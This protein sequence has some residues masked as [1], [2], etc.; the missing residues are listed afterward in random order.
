MLSPREIEYC[1]HFIEC[2]GDKRKIAEKMKISV[3]TAER[4]L[5]NIFVK[6]L[7]NDKTE[8]MYYLFTQQWKNQL[9]LSLKN[10]FKIT[11][12]NEKS[13]DLEVFNMQKFI[14]YI[15][16]FGGNNGNNNA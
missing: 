1:K 10:V 11:K 16:Q 9:G 7:V 15:L 14:R 8:L 6:L 4:H 5:H 13:Y 12:I 2:K 3:F